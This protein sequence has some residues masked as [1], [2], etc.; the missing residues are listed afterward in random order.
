VPAIHGL[1]ALDITNAAKP[2]EVSRLTLSD[3]YNS[4]WT[5]WGAKTQR[6]V[7]TSGSDRLYLLKLDAL[8][9]A[10]SLDDA[11]RGTDGKIGFT[12]AERDWPHG[13]KGSGVAHGAIFSR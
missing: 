7:A 8:T 9:G 10:L 3:T 13:W 2:V 11:F 6:L 5:A 1:I 4:H 12:F